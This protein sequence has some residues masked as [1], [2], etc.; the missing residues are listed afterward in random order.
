MF[1][2]LNNDIVQYII[3]EWITTKDICRL[4]VAVCNHSLRPLYYEALQTS[5]M[6]I[7]KNNKIITEQILYKLIKWS[8]KR[9]IKNPI[10]SIRF[11]EYKPLYIYQIYDKFSKEFKKLI[12]TNK[13]RLEYWDPSFLFD[14]FFI[15]ILTISGVRVY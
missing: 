3:Y 9:Q 13:V 7:I 12:Y 5:K 15:Q 11:V 6:P 2:S 8:K 4:D 14:D 1:T 10:E